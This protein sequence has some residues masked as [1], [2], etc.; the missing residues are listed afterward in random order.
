MI[1]RLKIIFLIQTWNYVDVISV[2][3]IITFGSL[4]HQTGAYAEIS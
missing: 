2:F 4:L 1:A 3:V